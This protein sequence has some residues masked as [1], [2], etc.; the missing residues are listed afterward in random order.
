M[1]LSRTWE[2]QF[3]A[4]EVGSMVRIVGLENTDRD[5]NGLQGNV[6]AANSDIVTVRIE[7]APK[8]VV[9]AHHWAKT[10][11]IPLANIR[12]IRLRSPGV[13]PAHADSSLV[14]VAPRSTLAGLEVKD[15][16]TGE[17]LRIEEHMEQDD[18]L[19]FAGDPLDYVS[20]HRYPSLMHRPL[21]PCKGGYDRVLR[22]ADDKT[23]HRISTPFFL[24]PQ[25][26]AKLEPPGFPKL[27][28]DDIQ[29]NEGGCRDNFP[30]KVQSCYYSDMIYSPADP[31]ATKK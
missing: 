3:Q 27:K 19:I 31:T 25:D 20:A 9:A 21:V 18:I 29:G 1:S 22:S 23:K 12:N 10:V 6:E 17:W 15:F 30:W 2:R 8:A 11:S 28:F 16:H 5:L 4:P 7:G 13:Y 26:V 14:T 24:Y